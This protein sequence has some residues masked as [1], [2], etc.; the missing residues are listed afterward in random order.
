M[1]CDGNLFSWPDVQN[2]W[3]ALLPASML[4][5][6]LGSAGKQWPAAQG[7]HQGFGGPP[8]GA[9]ALCQSAY[10]SSL[11]SLLRLHSQL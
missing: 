9:A 4:V 7:L 6:V 8:Q 11:S 3:C 2:E 10:I 1:G 5:G